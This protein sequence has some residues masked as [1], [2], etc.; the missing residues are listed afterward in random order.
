MVLIDKLDHAS[1]VDGCTMA[2]GETVR[3]RHNDIAD[4]EAELLELLADKPGGRMI[5]VDGV[6]SMEGDIAPIPQLL[7]RLQA[8]RGA[9]VRR[10]GAF[11][12]RDRPDRRAAPWT[13]TA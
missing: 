13:T 2:R 6:F 1:I 10:R 9:P 12:G 5:A 11:A 4:L 7:D 3:F 8:L